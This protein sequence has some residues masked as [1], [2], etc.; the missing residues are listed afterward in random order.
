MDYDSLWGHSQYSFANGQLWSL[1]IVLALATSLTIHVVAG[2]EDEPAV[3]AQLISRGAA[4]VMLL[5]HIQWFYFRYVTH[6][7]LF[8]IDTDDVERPRFEN[9]QQQIGQ[10]AILPWRSLNLLSWA[11]VVAC[12]VLGWMTATNLVRTT[13]GLAQ[14]IHLSKA[15]AGLTLLPLVGITPTMIEA[16]LA[17]ADNRMDLALRLTLQ[18]SID[19]AYIA[20]PTLVL[21]A[22]SVGKSML[23]TFGFL[24][25]VEL[26]VS[27]WLIG[28][29]FSS[30]KSTYLDGATML[31]LYVALRLKC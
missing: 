14:T 19:I 21:T 13:E 6:R 17:A 12:L 8:Q 4:P 3:I 11:S 20:F 2:S 18:S 29:I 15:A 10:A 26:G 5:I 25:L 22:W 9:T 27:T 24:E 1:Q 16:L 30:G 7:E 23:M 28:R 31:S